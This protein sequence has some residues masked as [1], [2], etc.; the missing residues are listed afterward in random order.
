MIESILPTASLITNRFIRNI[1]LRIGREYLGNVH[2]KLQLRIGREYFGHDI[3]TNFN[4]II[5]HLQQQGE[6]LLDMPLVTSSMF[7]YG[8]ESPS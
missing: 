1:R 8:G 6:F 3:M 2:K 4:S 7:K 5:S